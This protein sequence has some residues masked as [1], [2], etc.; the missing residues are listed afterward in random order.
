VGNYIV[1]QDLYDEGLLESDYSQADVNSRIDFVEEWIER[2]C[3]QWFYPQTMS[4]V[5]D[6]SDNKLLVLDI[7]LISDPP[8][9]ISFK[10]GS[11]DFVAQRLDGFLYYTQFPDDRHY[12]RIRINDHA[13]NRV[14]LQIR[15]A[16]PRGQRNVKVTG[17]W[18]YVASDNLSPPKAI[19]HS[20]KLLVMDWIEKV[21]TGEAQEANLR[22]G[23][24]EETTD[25]HKYK[26]SE[27]WGVGNLTGNAIVDRMLNK[28]KRQ[29]KVSATSGYETDY[30]TPNRMGNV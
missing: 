3:R 12:P 11:G 21:G 8:T 28:Y 4:R 2:I 9:E 15:G 29:V 13:R 19:V 27:S 6:G 17:D 26:L 16:F 1:P 25:G 22:N 20:T 5:F 7:P 30:Y 18:G 24:I 10:N 14:S 23:M